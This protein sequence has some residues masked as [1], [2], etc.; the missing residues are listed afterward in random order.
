MGICRGSGVAGRRFCEDCCELKAA[1]DCELVAGVVFEGLIGS[2]SV[3][4]CRRLP[5][6]G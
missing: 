1:D 3:V 5:R 6:L 4:S 2:W